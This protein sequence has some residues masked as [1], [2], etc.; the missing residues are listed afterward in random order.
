MFLK[1]YFS[2]LT[3]QQLK[4]KKQGLLELVEDSPY[5]FQYAKEPARLSEMRRISE[6]NAMHFAFKSVY[7]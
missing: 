1:R 2:T 4:N 5:R 7:Q 3:K 6:T